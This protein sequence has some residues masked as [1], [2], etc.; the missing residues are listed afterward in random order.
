MSGTTHAPG[1]MPTGKAALDILLADLNPQ[2]RAAAG[3]GSGPLLIVA[4]AGTGK[5]TTLAHRVATLIARGTDPGRILLLTFTRRSAAELLRR[6]DSLLAR[7]RQLARNEL[8]VPDA[9]RRV[10]GGTFHAVATRLLRQHGSLIGLEPSFTIIDRADAEDLMNWLRSD[11]QLAKSNKRFPLKG[12]CLDIYSRVVNT[13]QPLEVVLKE[14]FPW[15]LDSLD[16]LKQLFTAYTERK[17]QQQT[18]DYDDLLLFWHHLATEPASTTYIQN[19]FDCVLVDE[20]QDTNTLQAEI[21]K[22]IAPTG[23]G[24]TVVGD[25][26]QSIYSFR[27]ATVRNILDFPQMFPGVTVMPLEQNYRSTQQILD[28]TNRVIE[29][30]SEGHRKTLWSGRSDGNKPQMVT[31]RDEAEQCDAVI[32]RILAH[33]EVGVDLKKQAVLFRAGHHSLALEVELSRRNIPFHKF[34]G[35]KFVEAAHVKDVLAFLRLAENP[36]DS[37]SALR[38][39]LLL[40]GIGP[41][42]AT[43]LVETLASH[44]GDFSSWSSFKPPEA[45]ALHWPLFLVLLRLLGRQQAAPLELQ[46]ELHHIRS[47]YAPL[48]E[49]KFDD[50]QARARDLEQ[51]EHLAARF[52]SRVQFLNEMTL[53]PPSSTQDFAGDPYLDEDYLTLSTMHSAKGLEWEA[54]YVLHAADG[55]IPADLATRNEAEIEEERRLFY[56]ALTRARSSLYVLQPQRYYFHP[57]FKSDRHSFSQRTRFLPEELMPWF[58]QVAAA[59]N[60]SE[61]NASDP[62]VGSTADVRRKVGRMWA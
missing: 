19:K 26:A 8:S 15:V 49:Q 29:L 16:G 48:L 33:R 34:G 4:G 51:L 20:Y 10:C 21:V 35:L 59:R 25:D 11:L 44:Q 52:E 7:W 17:E 45:T 56:V 53:D 31:C 47:F 38:V 2:Q 24:L 28:V 13:Q 5:T 30:A 58:E 54:V 3:H 32:E 18:L 62:A 43:S 50:A 1:A 36:R 39:L 14:T 6:V 27:A 42:K 22:G 40:P 61:G 55:N 37:V 60:P 23:T 57:H 46:M 9:S 41:R 12:T